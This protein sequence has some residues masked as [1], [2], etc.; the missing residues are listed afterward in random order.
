MGFILDAL[1]RKYPKLRRWEFWIERSVTLIS[2]VLF[3]MIFF[4]V[5][6]AFENNNYCV[7]PMVP[8]FTS[9][10]YDDYRNDTRYFPEFNIT[11][12][13]S[14]MTATVMNISSSYEHG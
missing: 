7:A 3:L 10:V 8:N 4:Q 5:R 14:N 13:K 1:V 6:L 11:I 2:S 12:P 9:P